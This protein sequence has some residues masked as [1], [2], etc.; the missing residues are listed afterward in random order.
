MNGKELL[1]GVEYLHR[2]KNI[3]REVI[4]SSIE[5]A[6]RLAIHKC[7][8]D[9]EGIVVSID[10]A[11]GEIHAQKGETILAPD[12]LG[13]IPAQAAKQT[14]IQILREEESQNVFDQYSAQKGDLVH[15]TVQRFEGGA[16]TV[17]IAKVEALLPRG[18]Q[19]PGESHHVGERVKAVI[20]DVRKVGHRVKI[21][22]S[23]NHPDFV[24]R[25]FESEIPEIEDQTIS[26]KAVAREAGHRTKVA[27]SSIDMKV[28]CVGA[29]V[30]VRGSRIKNIID[31][32]GGERID[33]VRWNDSLQV[34]IPNALQ[35]A[36]IED[37]ML[38]PRLGRAIV[39]VK[40]DQL[41]LA[42]GR[43]GQ[44]V[45]LAS[46]L[47]G[48]DIEIMTHDELN[49]GI[50]KAEGWFTGLPHVTPEMVEAF[51][52]EGFLSFT[53]LT[54]VEA[55]ELAELGGVTED[56]AQE[57]IDFAEEEAEKQE[58]EARTAKPE[59]PVAPSAP[60]TAASKAAKLFSGPLGETAV[61]QPSEAK[62]T[63]ESLFGPA[64]EAPASPVAESEQPADEAFG[65]EPVATE[66]E[67]PTTPTEAVSEPLS[68]PAGEQ[69]SPAPVDSAPAE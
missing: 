53:D 25:L 2:E 23:R 20:L 30:G 39:L 37:V 65:S 3:S 34:L 44:N 31:E 45:R 49:S 21:I 69:A 46:K 52:E 42:I 68:E 55:A 66:E 10:R 18:E 12:K 11:T 64:A 28:D 38:Y 36:Q 41:S 54:F 61:P 57:I 9:E 1:T 16:A 63:F 67:Q 51:I 8:E 32:L 14:I 40:E 48:W 19:I 15:G 47:V 5:K 13:R 35:P 33:I 6:V 62:Q 43:R 17:T 4:F 7:Y 26:I 50:E 27:V 24:R 60:Q 56:Q 29:C 58:E 22:L 59:P